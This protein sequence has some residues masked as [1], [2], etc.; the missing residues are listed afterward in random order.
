MYFGDPRAAAWYGKRAVLYIRVST[1]EQARH[2]YSLDAQREDLLSFCERFRVQVV[3]LEA[4]E[5]VSARKPVNRRPALCRVLDRVRAGAVDYVLFIKLDRWFRSV[6]EY[7]RTQAVLEEAGVCWKATQEE[8]DTSTTNGRLNLNIRLSVAQD[9][10]DRTGDRIRFVFE[11]RVKNGFAITGSTSY[12]LAVVDHRLAVVEE[13]RQ[14]V[15]DLF[16]HYESTG[17]ISSCISFLQAR[18]GLFLSFARVRHMLSNTLYCGQYRENLEYC[19]AIISPAQFE[20]VQ[21]LLKVNTCDGQRSKKYDYI[22]SGLIRCPSCGRRLHGNLVTSPSTNGSRNEYRRY[23]CA[24][25][26]LDK[27]CDYKY[28]VWE[29]RVEDGVLDCVLPQLEQYVA[30]FDITEG[31]RQA[32][33]V[34]TSKIERRINRLQ[35][36]YLEEAI[37]IESYRTR[38]AA[39][40]AELE[41]ARAQAA[42]PPPVR[43]LSAVRELLAGDFRSIYATL[44]NTEKRLLWVSVIDCI[45]ITAS[46]HNN[47]RFDVIFL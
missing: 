36:L 34:D 24:A 10:S 35:D 20:R 33:T 3:A 30:K 46:G 21:H 32:V 6:A 15:V 43:D 5:G 38:Y 40:T 27:V 11:Q 4:D 8:Y 12:G 45:D 19:P 13:Q 37:D 14:A 39:L 44:T 2:G 31:K 41:A 7:Y 16:T 42:A 47:W 18:H 25:H 23:R 22:F 9:E 29:K 28:M 17:S 1:D 26:Y